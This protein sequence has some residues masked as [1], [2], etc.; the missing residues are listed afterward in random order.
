M[1][2]AIGFR[3]HQDSFVISIIT[4][5]GRKNDPAKQAEKDKLFFHFT[6]LNMKGEININA[7]I[8]MEQIRSV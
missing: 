4:I 6:L 7:K 8:E 1:T 5:A 2:E 3:E